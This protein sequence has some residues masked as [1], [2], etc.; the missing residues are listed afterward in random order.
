MKKNLSPLPL[1]IPDMGTSAGCS[2]LRILLSII[3]EIERV[4]PALTLMVNS[5]L[6]P[7]L[8]LQG[9]HCL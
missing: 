8:L 6:T 7:T 4:V 3:W 9:N 1:S 2:Q 5:V